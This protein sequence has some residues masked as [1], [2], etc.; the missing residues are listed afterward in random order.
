MLARNRRVLAVIIFVLNPFSLVAATHGESLRS[1]T[2]LNW[3]PDTASFYSSM[4]R[5][6]EQLDRFLNSRAY[7][8][9]MSMP[10]VQMGM[11][12]LKSQIADEGGQF[13]EFMKDPDNQALVEFVKDAVSHEVFLYGG[14]GFEQLFGGLIAMSEISNRLQI[15]SIANQGDINEEEFARRMI[16]RIASDLKELDMPRFVVGFR[17]SDP[18]QATAQLNRLEGLIQQGLQE[19]PE[20]ASA[21]KKQ[22]IDGSQ[23]LTI[24]LDSSMIPWDE[25]D[26]EDEQTLE[27][28][29]SALDGKQAVVALGLRDNYLMLQM[30]KSIQALQGFGES[31]KKL[32]DNE[33]LAIVRKHDDKPVTG[34]AYVNGEFMR[35][36]YQPKRQL[37]GFL[38]LAKTGLDKAPFD[39][40]LKKSLAKDADELAADIKQYYPEMGAVAVVH[41]MTD[42]GYVSFTQNWSEN[43]MID[44]S[45]PLDILA[46]VGGTPLA[47]FAYRGQRTDG[48][49]YKMLSKWMG[50]LT[51]YGQKLAE[52]ELE[53]EAKDNYEEAVDRVM[54]L[55]QKFDQVTRDDFIPAF[56]D[57]QSAFVLD[58]KIE[59]RQ[60]HLMMPP[61]AEPLPMFEVA[62]V[63]GVTDAR[64]LKSAFTKYG[65]VA[66]E[67]LKY[68]QE[69]TAENQ[70]ALMDNLDG[71]AQMLPA[72]IESAKIP[73]PTSRESDH[74]TI[75][76]FGGM[77][78]V[79]LDARIAP[80]AGISADRFV[81][82]LSPKT[83]ER[84]LKKSELNAT[85]PLTD[86]A[87]KN[88]GTAV[89]VDMAGLIGVIR[90]WT[91]YGMATAA[92][93]Q[94]DD[95]IAEFI[96]T[97]DGIIEILQCYRSIES[98]TYI[99]D[100]S[101]VTHAQAR[102]QD[103]PE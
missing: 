80:T 64:K 20:L 83:T 16:D 32:I 49:G 4:L 48:R 51:S 55:M 99:D 73:R 71:P 77:A 53:G 62:Q 15:E 90:A 88:L 81:F 12:Q 39:E 3:I 30:G 2:S 66:D 37:D 52:E 50:R 76:E 56:E 13:Q 57:G 38:E 46:N 98:V 23:C 96:P 65:E 92:E 34:V 41:Y 82:S 14:N 54:P 95:Q 33:K 8:R 79:G 29:K 42:D 85:G 26:I 103:L 45:K 40:E 35:A 84:L 89:R 28:L 43:L 11:S 1:D 87:T 70:E 75:Y 7:Q 24:T 94:D 86:S 22:A 9:L 100:D 21:Y 10:V 61:A 59:S 5:T 93:L 60:W 67:L 63:C 6:R 44:G 97:V 78:Q 58:G 102:F 101:M 25:V 68:T 17:L 47:M 36:I 74:G 31:G 18:A 91:N 72:L 19:Q 69:I 27:K